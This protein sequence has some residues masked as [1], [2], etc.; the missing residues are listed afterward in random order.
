M[1]SDILSREIELKLQLTP[2]SKEA[3]LSAELLGD[4]S[5]VLQQRAIYFDTSD[6]KLQDA[7]FSVRIRQVGDVRTQTIK[8]TSMSTAGL[9]ARPEWERVVE[10]DDPV[11]DHGAPIATDLWPVFAIDELLALFTVQIERKKWVRRESNSEIEVVLDE[12]FVIS[13]DRQTQVLEVE[14]EL[15][16][17]EQ[18]D[19]FLAARSIA[20]IASVRMGVLSK[21]ERGY[22]LLA[23]AQSFFK[24]EMMHLDQSETAIGA[25]QAIAQ[26]CFRQ[27]RLNET[28]LLDRRN[29][30]AL[31]QARVSLRRLRSAFSIF[32]P[33]IADPEAFRINAELRWLAS[34]LGEA[35]NID[36]L[37]AKTEKGELRNRLKLLKT[38]K[39]DQVIEALKSPRALSLE[40]DFVEWLWCGKYLEAPGTADARQVRIEEFA[41]AALDRLRK[42]IKRHAIALK[43]GTDTERHE[44]RKDAKKFR[45]AAEFFASLYDDKHGRR[46][47]K[48][49]SKAMEEL[50]DHLGALNDMVTGP[51]VLRDHDLVGHPEAQAL[52]STSGKDKLLKVSE[53]VLDDLVDAKKFWR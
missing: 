6:H 37:I 38:E 25:F 35:R 26:S 40:M 52:V 4:P 48:Q 12:G 39:Y 7:G 49:F 51:D 15:K 1:E 19:L 24:A 16:D 32:K 33:I 20:K 42:K 11:L 43:S 8:A 44:V 28:V 18:N 36:V 2:E 5:E 14:L 23:P 41:S 46:R 31:H 10:S 34:I 47:F 30:E 22:R 9:F 27:F 45:Y 50:Q 3:L 53:V 21:S 17:G 29:S 13:G